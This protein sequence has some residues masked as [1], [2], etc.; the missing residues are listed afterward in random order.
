MK[1]LV[2]LF[3]FVLALLSG[4]F[5]LIFA[6]AHWHNWWSLCAAPCV[7]LAFFLPALCYGYQR[8]DELHL[9]DSRM[10][11]VTFDNCRDLG[12]VAAAMVMLCAYGVPVLAW[13]NAGFGYGGV[14]TVQGALTCQV[15][16]FQLWLRI[17]IFR[18]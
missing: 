15:A 6:C 13:Y 3:C 7:G 10:D 8:R 11:S 4:A 9:A 18:E 16:A 1:G 12:W 2:G 5:L 14:I 17:F